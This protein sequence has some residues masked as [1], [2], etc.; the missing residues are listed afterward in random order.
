MTN[1]SLSNNKEVNQAIKIEVSQFIHFSNE[2][3]GGMVSAWLVVDPIKGCVYVSENKREIF[4]FVDVYFI[5]DFIQIGNNGF[6]PNQ[7]AIDRKFQ[8]K[9]NNCEV[10]DLDI[11]I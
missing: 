9:Q 7:E 11:D 2:C 3:Y 4:G 10:E 6:E 5:D 1:F 8:I